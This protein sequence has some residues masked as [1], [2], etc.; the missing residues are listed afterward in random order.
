MRDDPSYQSAPRSPPGSA[1]LP[2]EPLLQ[3]SDAEHGL[4]T[5]G[6]VEVFIL[7]RQGY[8]VLLVPLLLLLQLLSLLEAY[9]GEHGDCVN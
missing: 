5:V 8:L 7:R 9:R 1:S 2:I 3:D 6:Q 4:R